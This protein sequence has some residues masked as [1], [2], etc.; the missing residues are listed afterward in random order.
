MVPL[1]LVIY[2]NY[3]PDAI[4]GTRG[5]VSMYT[6]DTNMV[7][8]HENDS[9]YHA[10]HAIDVVKKWCAGNCLVLNATKTEC[11]MF[12]TYRGTANRSKESIKENKMKFK[13]YTKVLGV[14]LDKHFKFT[15]YIA[16]VS[17]KLTSSTYAI[18]ILMYKEVS[19]EVL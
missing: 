1:L 9:T 5:S 8:S 14:F 10:F 15:T 2:V 12:E 19:R 4:S 17:K 7:V 18:K 3:L 11:M 6:D 16:N 13:Q